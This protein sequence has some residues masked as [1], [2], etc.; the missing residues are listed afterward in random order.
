MTRSYQRD[1]HHVIQQAGN[2]EYFTV[3]QFAMNSFEKKWHSFFLVKNWISI[4]LERLNFEH[5]CTLLIINVTDQSLI[6]GG[7]FELSAELVSYRTPHGTF[8]PSCILFSS[9]IIYLFHHNV[10][11]S[12]VFIHIPFPILA[13]NWYLLYAVPLCISSVSLIFVWKSH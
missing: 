2:F 4:I 10:S 7:H 12:E 8:S 13:R 11:F 1:I 6:F 5:S 3:Q 9:W